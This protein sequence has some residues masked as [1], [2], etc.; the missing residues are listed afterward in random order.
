MVMPVG[1]ARNQA[2][3]RITRDAAGYHQEELEYCRFVKL[4]GKYG[5][6]N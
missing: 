2:L 3:L 6:R 1:D 4:V 5:W